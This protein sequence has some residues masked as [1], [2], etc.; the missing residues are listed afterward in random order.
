ML[1]GNEAIW[2]D[3]YLASLTDA[4]FL[5][6]Q[7]E[8]PGIRQTPEFAS[9]LHTITAGLLSDSN[10]S[11][12]SPYDEITTSKKFA[13]FFDQVRRWYGHDPKTFGN[14]NEPVAAEFD[15]NLSHETH[16]SSFKVHVGEPEQRTQQTVADP[17]LPDLFGIAG[18]QSQLVE[19]IGPLGADKLGFIPAGIA[20]PYQIQ[21]ENAAD[22]DGPI[23]EIQ[24]VQQIDPSLDVHTFRLGDIRL[25]DMVVH[26]P[27]DRGAFVGDFDFK[28]DRGIVLRVTAGIDVV[29]RTAIWRFTA[30][31][32][33]T[34]LKTDDPTLGILLPNKDRTQVGS[35]SYTIGT[36][37]AVQ[38]G[39]VIRS[40]ARIFFDGDAPLDTNVEMNVIDAAALKQRSQVVPQVTTRLRSPGPPRMTR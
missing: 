23:S 38:T 33:L 26:V 11:D 8:P 5:R 1:A 20:L 29:S 35:L 10:V 31:D 40:S 37:A 39:D 17:N 36:K 32:P 6:A 19:M 28:R 30:I 18:D 2:T 21:F 14:Q 3:L 16:F 24:I 7:D 13:G 22:A 25:G 15:L 27:S 4:G 12:S 9:L 34:G